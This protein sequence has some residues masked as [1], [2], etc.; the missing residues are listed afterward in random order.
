MRKKEKYVQGELFKPEEVGGVSIEDVFTAYFACRNRK[1]STYNSLAFEVD[2]ERNCVEL[3]KSINCHTY[4]PARSIVF[5]I[6]RPVLREVFAPSFESRVVDHLIAAKIEPLLEQQFID[7]NYATRRGRGTLF[8]INRVSEMLKECSKD[9]TQDCYIMKLDIKSYFMSLNK[10]ALYD[11]MAAFV[12]EHYHENDLQTLLYM[13]K[14]II[15]DRPETHC[16]RRSPRSS[17]KLLPP[18]KSLFNNDGNHGM[19]IGRLTSQMCAAYNLDPLDHKIKEEWGIK[20]YG[21][22]VDDMVLID[23]SKAHLLEVKEQIRIWLAKRG[24][25]LHPKKVYL[26]HYSKGVSF[27]GGK[28]LPGRNYIHNRSLSFQHEYIRAMNEKAIEDDQFVFYHGAEFVT[29]LNSYL[30]IMRHFKSYNIRKRLVR[31]VS[32]EWYQVMFFDKDITKAVLKKKFHAVELAQGQ[33]HRDLQAK[34]FNYKK[35]S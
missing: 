21:R 11:N 20:Y 17:W 29:T 30:G 27:I 33:I 13:L 14:A 15:F 8:G 34:K 10:Q 19:P 1:R 4:H 2:Y 23:P 25:T 3:W 24:Y 12:T 31:S 28:I 18:S 5:I 22:Y 7:D 6:S 26:Q 9:Y 32:K 16:V 35:C